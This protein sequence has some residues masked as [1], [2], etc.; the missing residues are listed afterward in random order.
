MYSKE[1]LLS[2]II[3]SDPFYFTMISNSLNYNHYQ[4]IVV[5]DNFFISKDLTSNIVFMY[6]KNNVDFNQCLSLLPEQIETL[7]VMGYCEHSLIN[8]Y[9]FDYHRKTYQFEYRSKK[10]LKIDFNHEIRKIFISDF[11]YIKSNYY[12]TGNDEGYFKNAILERTMF[13]LEKKGKLIGFIGEHPELAMGLLFV[14]EKERRKGYGTILEKVM[15]NFI[16]KNNRVPIEHVETNNNS[17][18]NLQSKINEI[19]RN[20][21]LINWFF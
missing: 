21:Q 8:N 12:R 7:C 19:S 17:S 16:I 1:K 6:S 13:G 11:E 14:E 10:E 3:Q 18:I 5:N 2:K 20:Q 15:I 4:I 9:I